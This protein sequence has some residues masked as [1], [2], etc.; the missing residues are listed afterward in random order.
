MSKNPSDYTV[1]SSAKRPNDTG[2]SQP[3][4]SQKVKNS[5]GNAWHGFSKPPILKKK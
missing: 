3:L 2:E 5:S 1:S 4:K